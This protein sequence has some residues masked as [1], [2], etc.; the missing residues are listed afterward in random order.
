MSASQVTAQSFVEQKF[1]LDMANSL[2]PCPDA[3]DQFCAPLLRSAAFAYDAVMMVA[4]AIV[5]AKAKCVDVSPGVYGNATLGGAMMSALRSVSFNGAS[6]PI[7]FATGSN[8]RLTSNVRL[9]LN[10]SILYRQFL[11]L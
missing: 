6:G 4:N 11:F 3:D 10:Q 2:T 9:Q 8:D 5:A 7:S 1:I